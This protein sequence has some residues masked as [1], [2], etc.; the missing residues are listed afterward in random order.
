MEL[1]ELLESY[2]RDGVVKVP[3][4]FPADDMALI[5]EAIKHYIAEIVPGLPAADYVLEADGTTVRNC[6]R[7]EAHDPFFASLASRPSLLN[8]VGP[9]VNGEPVLMAVE[10]FNKPGRVGSGVPPHQDNAY[11]C[12]S[13]ADA[14]TV[15]IA[16]DAV[17]EANGPVYYVP[18]SHLQGPRLHAPS[19]VAG[20]SMGLLESPPAAPLFCELPAPG[21]ALLHHAET[22][23]YSAPNTSDASRCGLLFVYRGAHCAV[24]P[25]LRAAYGAAHG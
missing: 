16:V 14:V 12:L 23:H 2:Q 15:W 13:P 24:D 10:T 25:A 20:N 8:L 6:W 7:M 5:R 18:G 9:C 1:D 19:G 21:D 11:F 3:G 4:L 22:I 17:S